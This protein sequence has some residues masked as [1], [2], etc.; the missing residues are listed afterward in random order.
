MTFP[1]ATHLRFVFFGMFCCMG[2][3]AATAPIFNPGVSLPTLAGPLAS[4]TGDFNKDGNI[5][6]A[7]S[8][9]AVDSLSV[10]LGNGDGTFQPRVD[11][12]IA[13]CQVDQVITGDFNRDGNLDLLGT[14]TLTPT[15]F[16]LPGKGDGTFGAPILSSA[17]MPIVSGF[18]EN[19]VQPLTTADINGDGILD[20]ALIIQTSAS[21]T[22]GSPGAIGQ[23]VIL[24]GNGDGTFGHPATLGTIAPSGTE[25]YAV[26]LADVNGDG[27]P[28]IVGV[29]FDYTYT[30]LSN[31]LV[32][33][34]FVAL[35]DGTGGFHFADSYPL[36][37]IP[38][39]GMMLAD[40]NGDGHVDVVFAGLSIAA[41]L[42]GTVSDFS[43]V[44][45]FLG[46]GKGGFTQGYTVEDSQSVTNQASI[47]AALAPVFGNSVPDLIGV[48]YYQALTGDNAIT[49]NLVVRPNNG[50]GV[51]G[52]PQNLYAPSAVLPF[53]IAVADFNGDGTPDI[54]A[55]NYTVSLFNL[56]FDS[57]SIID[58]IDLIG[59]TIATFPAATLSVLLNNTLSSTFTNANSASYATGSLASASIASAFGTGLASSTADATSQPLPL[60][61]AGTSVSVTDSLG[62]TRSAPL[63]Y[64]SSKQ[65]NY[66][67]PDGTATGTA[68]VSITTAS[69]TSAIQQPIVGVAPGIFN[70]GGL[71][72][73]NVLT[74]N[75]GASTPVVTSTLEINSQN[76]LAPAP[77][78]LDSGAQVYLVLFGTGIRNHQNAV[79]A[80]FS[81][82]SSA[83]APL[84]VAY[85]GAQGI[86][87]G[88]DQINILLP[89]SLSGFGLADVTLTA[90]G[91]TTNPVQVLF[92]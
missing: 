78:S 23:T 37:G 35:G 58:D 51:F 45:V 15:I 8:N 56:L 16:V 32:A 49:G 5:D 92:Q 38:Q 30:G 86:F 88:E 29:A 71:A 57:P 63:F 66:E 79:T 20:L 54:V 68:M 52:P 43:G 42:N 46:D 89:S 34:F 77:I 33:Y 13:G 39:T 64:V 90:D 83:G 73:A 70:A 26:Q 67:I 75:S 65:I 4:I 31:P 21:V 27:K 87:V 2:V 36:A 60:T 9:T 1:G 55:F 17:P 69:G 44:G 28:D 3:S 41:I 19:F 61:L 7:V 85:A 47:G 18:L 84:A 59:Q 82:K 25:T 80:S 50:E 14:C 62:A 91:Q 6:L 53:S 81:N 24:T 76:Q 40:V 74:Y 12:A 22:L 48:M 10:F 11:Y 72:A